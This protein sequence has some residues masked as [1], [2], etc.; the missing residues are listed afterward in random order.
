ML[1]R[2]NP[3]PGTP[4]TP[5]KSPAS[6]PGRST[7][8]GG[9]APAGARRREVAGGFGGASPPPEVKSGRMPADGQV[10][11]LDTSA[12]PDAIRGLMWPPGMADDPATQSALAGWSADTFWRAHLADASNG[13]GLLLAVPSYS[14]FVCGKI[15]VALNF[16]ASVTSCAFE[17][18][19]GVGVSQSS[20][21][22]TGTESDYGSGTSSTQTLQGT[23]GSGVQAG[24][25]TSQNQTTS[26]D[27]SGGTTAD[28]TPGVRFRFSV[29]WAVTMTTTYASI[30]D[31]AMQATGGDIPA[32][33]SAVAYGDGVVRFP[34]V[35]C[36][37]SKAV[38][39]R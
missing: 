5:A 32:Q 38:A 16:R 27:A 29:R 3:A 8:T 21:A 36:G 15:D 20:D 4:A 12:I 7:L 11:D 14:S 23:S 2:S 19:D 13:D 37:G 35:R 18:D 25:S 39:L 30:A 28:S 31:K 24:T 6:A 26:S 34:K 9:L 10:V 33:Q 1:T 22:S 17:A